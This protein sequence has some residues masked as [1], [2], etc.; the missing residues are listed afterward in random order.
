M[1]R[2]C[3]EQISIAESGTFEYPVGGVNRPVRS[4]GHDPRFRAGHA[5]KIRL[6]F[7]PPVHAAVVD[8]RSIRRL[9]AHLTMLTVK[10]GKALH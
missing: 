4:A 10:M 3:S 7:Q 2:L 1:K 6:G 5:Q 8:S 9:A